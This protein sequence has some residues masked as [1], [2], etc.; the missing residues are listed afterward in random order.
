[1]RSQAEIRARFDLLRHG[2]EPDPLGFKGEAII[3]AL[4][5]DTMLDLLRSPDADW[6]DVDLPATMRDYLAF[7]VGKALG[8]R[9]ISATR[10]VEKFTIWIWCLADQDLADRFESADYPQYGAPKLQVLIEHFGL[11]NL[12]EEIRETLD[13]EKWRRMSRGE[14]CVATCRDGC[15]SEVTL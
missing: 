5:R 14:F 9:G 11:G 8:H 4:D 7:A 12:P 6:N 1:M 13:T 10:S 15:G 3:E 2:E